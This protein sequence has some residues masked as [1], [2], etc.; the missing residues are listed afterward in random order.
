MTLT[1]V[2]ACHRV[3][4]GWAAGP[5]LADDELAERLAAIGAV[6]LD[7]PKGCGNTGAPQELRV[8]ASAVSQPQTDSAVL[9]TSSSLRH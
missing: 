3:S 6:L 1:L 9:T 8:R 2:L 7:G 4:A 5:S